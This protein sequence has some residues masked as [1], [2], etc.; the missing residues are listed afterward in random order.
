MACSA[1]LLLL[2]GVHNAWDNV[3]FLSL[4]KRKQNAPSEQFYDQQKDPTSREGR[5]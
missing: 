5:A 3:T 2:I 1:L 4:R